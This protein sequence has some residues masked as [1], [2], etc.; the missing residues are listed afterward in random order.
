MVYDREI[1]KIAFFPKWLAWVTALTEPKLENAFFMMNFLMVI[2][3]VGNL[4][5]K[6]RTLYLVVY[7][8]ISIL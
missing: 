4:Q 6:F 8:Y 1:I 5:E 7:I 2:I 3:I